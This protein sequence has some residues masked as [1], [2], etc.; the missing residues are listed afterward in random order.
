[1]FLGAKKRILSDALLYS[2]IISFVAGVLTALVRVVAGRVPSLASDMLNDMVWNAQ[3][4]I[5]VFQIVLT[6]LVFIYYWRLLRHYIET[7][8]AEERRQMGLLQEEYL[9][10][11][12]PSLTAEDVNK[13]L[14]I[15]G[16][17]L[18][19]SE[20]IYQVTST[21]Y[22]DFIGQISLFSLSGPEGYGI[23]LNIYNRTHGFKYL[24]MMV[25]IILGITIT[26]IFLSD[27]YLKGCGIALSALFLLLSAI[28]N[29]NT[30][31]ILGWNVD[32]VWTSVLFHAVDMAGLILLA[33]Y[34]RKRYR[35]V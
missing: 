19:S 8:P 3:S 26:G 14:E 11:D 6:F 31:S 23:Y 10:K 20:I 16:V 33:I 35:G 7:V 24:G 5:S 28:I 32:I 29:R 13:L 25:A 17:I 22:R 18:V 9:G 1:M 21:I 2:S 4:V 15:W 30:V 34:L 12:I 27:R